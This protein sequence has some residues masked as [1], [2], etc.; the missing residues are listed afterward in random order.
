MSDHC[1]I[2]I[3][4]LDK[5]ARK[6]SLALDRKFPKWNYKKLNAD[7]MCAAA[8]F[9]SWVAGSL[10]SISACDNAEW[11][12]RALIE[13]SDIAMPKSGGFF[14]NSAYWNEEVAALRTTL[15]KA[16]RK[17]TRTIGG[18]RDQSDL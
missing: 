13:I 4:L 17:L 16:R 15:L 2:R 18:K 7:Y 1:L 10:V 5:S 12:N 8:I 11:M 3:D 9:K 14:R 6:T